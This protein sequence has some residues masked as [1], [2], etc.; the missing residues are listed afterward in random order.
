MEPGSVEQTAEYVGHGAV[1]DS[2]S[3]ILDG[4]AVF[5]LGEFL[6]LDY[7]I[8]EELA[9]LTGIEGVVDRFL[10]THEKGFG[11]G[12]ET[13]YLLVLLEEFGDRN[14]MLF[15]SETLSGHPAVSCRSFHRLVV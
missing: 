12:V 14:L 9:L 7:D 2:G 8:G 11:A 4:Y 13:Q 5:F 10:D 15:V 1:H 6:Y 3:I